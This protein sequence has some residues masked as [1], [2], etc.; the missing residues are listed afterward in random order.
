MAKSTVAKSSEQEE[1]VAKFLNA[2]RTPRSGGGINIKGDVVDGLSLF[3]CK[4]YMNEKDSFTVKREWLI[5][6]QKERF[7]DRKRFAFLVQNFG[8]KGSK[9][10]HVIMTIEDFKELYFAYR[11]SLELEEEV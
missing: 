4:T 8:G 3:E 2:K 5:K 9:D 1:F 6:N 11:N 10:N 7:E